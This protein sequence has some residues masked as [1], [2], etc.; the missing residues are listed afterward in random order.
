MQLAAELQISLRGV[1]AEVQSVLVHVPLPAAHLF[2]QSA[3]KDILPAQG[4]VP[5]KMTAALLASL[6]YSRLGFRGLELGYYRVLWEEGLGFR[7]HS[8]Q[9]SLQ[10]QS[11]VYPGGCKQQLWL[12]I[13]LQ[14][15]SPETEISASKQRSVGGMLKP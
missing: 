2:R 12:G 7:L 9:N 14:K 3:G 15:Q 1:V 11:P 4:L 5:K 8:F 6:T 13:R 10:Q